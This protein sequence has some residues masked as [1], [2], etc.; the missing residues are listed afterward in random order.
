MSDSLNSGEED[1]GEEEEE[2][3]EEE[4]QLKEEQ[5]K[6]EIERTRIEE[7]EEREIE[8]SE[9]YRQRI[10]FST[11]IIAARTY[12]LSNVIASGKG[13]DCEIVFSPFH[14]EQ[15]IAHTTHFTR[16][17]EI[18]VTS[19][20]A[21]LSCKETRNGWGGS[22]ELQYEQGIPRKIAKVWINQAMNIFSYLLNNAA[23]QRQDKETLARELEAV[24]AE[25]KNREIV[26]RDHDHELDWA[27]ADLCTNVEIE[28]LRP[29]MCG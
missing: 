4:E 23:A 14:K 12:S 5:F 9:R 28:F 10:E 22:G 18:L 25:G 15:R 20:K 26:R 21:L 24:R 11:N 13:F 17:F 27:I 1:E 29:K 8:E 6:E 2:E 16:R 19:K 3:E 7:K